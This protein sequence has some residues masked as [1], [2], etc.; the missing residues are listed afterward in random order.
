MASVG[1][2]IGFMINERGI[3]ANVKIVKAVLNMQGPTTVKKL[4]KLIGYMTTL[5][6]FVA[7]SA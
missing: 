3:E 5:G 4:Q 7:N 6:T 1:K 2:F